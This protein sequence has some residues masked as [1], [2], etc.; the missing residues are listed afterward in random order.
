MLYFSDV[1]LDKILINRTNYIYENNIVYH[2][3]CIHI[4]SPLVTINLVNMIYCKFQCNITFS[5]FH[6][7]LYNN[8]LI[9]MWRRGIISYHQRLNLLPNKFSNQIIMIMN[10]NTLI[11]DSEGNT[12]PIVH[13]HNKQCEIIFKPSIIEQKL[14]CEVEEIKLIK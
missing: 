6:Y 2:K 5:N 12:L 13:I 8:I 14:F 1:K 11:Y 10:K 9:K 4:T 3:Q 7:N